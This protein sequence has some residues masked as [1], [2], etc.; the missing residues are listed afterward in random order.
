MQ[1][2]KYLDYVIDTAKQ[3]LSIDSPS[4]F[5]KAAIDFVME[6]YK[7]LGFEPQLTAKGGI[8]VRLGGP[9]DSE[10]LLLSG[11]VDTLGGIVSEIKDNGNLRISP[12]GGLNPNNAEAENCRIVTRFDG[13]YEGTLQLD[14]ASTHVNGEYNDIMREFSKMEVVL[15]ED[16]SSAGDTKALGVA[17]GDYVCFEPRTT[18]TASGY[19]KSRFLDDK[20]G[21]SILLGYAKYVSEEKVELPRAVY[22]YITNYEEVGHGCASSIPASVKDVIS[23]D[24]GCVGEKLNCTEHQVS[25]CV[26][27]SK[28]PYNYDI[29][30][31]LVNAAKDCNVD[32]A[33]DVYPKY[34]SDADVALTS[35]H[36]VR[37]GL[38]GPGVY[39][40]HG[41]ERSHKDGVRNTLALL[42]A[43]LG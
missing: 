37:H 24:M 9:E 27:D 41:Y 1:A 31:D 16:V 36:D 5:S 33:L 34:G 30:T 15:D 18:L 11:H 13:T 38:I 35:G 12:I 2:D 25:I 6:E 29:I 32:Y 22:H 8:V 20:L 39:A 40:S 43:Y 7:K 26:K 21:V 14:N 3:L 28:G 19:I 4:G 23:V 42:I 10:G 17:V